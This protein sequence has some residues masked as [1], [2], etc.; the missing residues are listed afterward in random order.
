[1]ASLTEL[2]REQIA[3]HG[4]IPF[5]E[6]MAQ[7]LY[8][9]QHG[10]YAAG[11]ARIGRAGDFF[12]N[13]S[14]GPL[15][16]RLLARQ[17]IQVWEHLGAP[18]AF[19]IVE[20]GAHAGQ[21]ARDALGGLREF[22][23]EC[24]A[25]VRYVIVEPLPALRHQQEETLSGLPVCWLERLEELP[26]FTGIHFSN[27][28]LDAFPV[29][30]VVR[31]AAG[32]AERHVRWEDERFSFCEG[33]LSDPRLAGALE[34][35]TVEPGFVAEINLAARDW[36]DTIAARLERGCV[37]VIDYGYS[38]EELFQ[39]PAGTLSAYASHRREP[40]PLA[41]PGEIDLTAHV[42]F[43]GLLE[44][45]ARARLASCGLADQ[46]HFMVG[47]SRLHFTAESA[48]P[49]ELRAFKTLMHPALMG[50]AFK[51]LCLIK[52]GLAPLAGFEFAR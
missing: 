22:A 6:F 17:F 24:F 44:H 40:D 23:P 38:R 11:R 7:A 52:G 30:Q 25:A 16:G 46:H 10:Y 5:R 31:T 32:W 35:W 51:A 48:P 3:L 15:F 34:P 39:R 36:L 42:E 8:D 1:M 37:L 21:F 28:L 14:V 49:A 26:A 13:V 47:L 45:A 29:H 41:R 20:Q 27:E 9:P 50:A 33:P 4:P 12:T 18:A 19:T 43:T 2:L